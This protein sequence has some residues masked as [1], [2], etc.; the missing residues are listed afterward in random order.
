MMEHWGRSCKDLGLNVGYSVLLLVSLLVPQQDSGLGG[1][2][3][4]TGGVVLLRHPKENK[5]KKFPLPHFQE[6]RSLECHF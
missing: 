5:K 1:M 4:R 6:T 2:L 3:S